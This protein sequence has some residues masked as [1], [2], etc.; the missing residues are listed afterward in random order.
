R[1]PAVPSGLGPE[2]AAVRARARAR[3]APFPGN[4]PRRGTERRSLTGG[5]R[6]SG[7]PAW[8]PSLP[9][10]RVSA[11]PAVFSPVLPLPSRPEWHASRRLRAGTARR[12]RAG[13]PWWRGPN[14]G[15]KAAERARSG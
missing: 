7:R 2:K 5:A 9:L 11:S 3:V 8:Q 4:G 15:A 14:D 12:G 13:T 1:A 6:R 10:L